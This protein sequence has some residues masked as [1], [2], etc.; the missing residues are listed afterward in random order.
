MPVWCALGAADHDAVGTALHHMQVHVGVGLLAWG[1]LERSPLGSVMAPSTVR[2]LSW[3]VGQELLEVL[4]VV[5]AVLLV[6]LIGGGEHGV[7]GVHAHAALE[8]GWRSSGPAGAASSPCCT[9]SSVDKLML[10]ADVRT[11]TSSGK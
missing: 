2:S 8:A 10:S 9:R 1:A 4:V 11:K 3:T 7:E 6:D 5:G